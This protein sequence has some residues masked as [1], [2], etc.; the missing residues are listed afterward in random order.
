VAGFVQKTKQIGAYE[1]TVKRLPMSTGRA[2]L[3]RLLSVLAPA[4]GEA[5]SKGADLRS[6][7]NAAKGMVIGGGLVQA[8][9]E[10]LDDALIDAAA[11]AMGKVSSAKNEQ[12]VVLALDKPAIRDTV[13]DGDYLAF[14][15]WIAFG[16]EV[17][18]SDFFHGLIGKLGQEPLPDQ[19]KSSA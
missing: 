2:L 19:A 6:F 15:E 14:F 11:D 10:R 13:F 17:Q 9:G 12:G 7:A 4:L 3:V 8:F 5:L 1:F 18:Y 16:L